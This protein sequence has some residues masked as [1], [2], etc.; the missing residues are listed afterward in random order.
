MNK[1]THLLLKA[2][3]DGNLDAVKQVIDS[4]EVDVNATAY[5]DYTENNIKLEEATPLVLAASTCNVEIC[6]ILVGKGANVNSRSTLKREG[7]D[8]DVISPLHAA[9]SYGPEFSKK[10]ATIEF[11][12]AHGADPSALPT[13]G[14]ISYPMWTLC[15]GDVDLTTLLI[16][17]GLILPSLLPCPKTGLSVL[18]YWASSFYGPADPRYQDSIPIF[19]KLLFKG[20]DV[21]ALD[22]FS[23]TPL[24]AASFGY[25]GNGSLGNPN[26]PVLRYLLQRNDITQL[27]KINA[28]ELAGASILLF[29]QEEN[30]VSQAFKYL[31]EAQ[32]LRDSALTPKVP[33]VNVDNMV[34]WRATEWTTRD[35]LEQLQHGP[36]SIKKIQALLVARRILAGNSSSYSLVVLWSEFAKDFIFSLGRRPTAFLDI[37]WIILEGTTGHDL[38]DGLYCMIINVI[39]NVRVYW[40]MFKEE[41]NQILNSEA[42]KLL[43]KIVFDASNRAPLRLPRDI[44]TE[45]TSRNL[46]SMG[47]VVYDLVTIMIESPE[48]ITPDVKSCLQKFVKRDKRIN[49]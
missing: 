14:G 3:N 32:G 13:R 25:Y 36:P 42:F 38:S 46:D 19:E 39:S 31:F 28:L 33:K 18:H 34:D 7:K 1:S 44:C 47:F 17:L 43:L 9:I 49:R 4:E 11:L 27:E 30:S 37:I 45:W 15:L 10:K 8:T 40:R 24:N 41:H 23:L 16:D 12:I 26:E 22:E 29:K 6:K 20:A 35:Q 48:M 2:C 5:I 21:N